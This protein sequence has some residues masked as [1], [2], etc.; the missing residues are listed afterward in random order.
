MKAQ[1]I[2]ENKVLPRLIIDN[3]YFE[4]VN[5]GYLIISI[6]FVNNSNDTLR[7][8]DTSGQ[9][10]DFFVSSD[11]LDLR[12]IKEEDSPSV[13]Q[14]ILA[15]QSSKHIN[16]KLKTLSLLKGEHEFKIAM[17]FHPLLETRNF[18]HE[19]RYQST[20]ILTDSIWVTFDRYE[21]TYLRQEEWG[22]RREL[23]LPSTI[24]SEA[25]S[26]DQHTDTL[27][28]DER[29]ITKTFVYLFI[30]NA[31][32]KIRVWSEE[33]KLKKYECFVVPVTIHNYGDKTIYYASWS[34]S[35]YF[36]YQLNNDK[37]SIS[38]NY[39]DKNLRITIEVP[40]HTTRTQAVVIVSA[41]DIL[42]YSEVTKI[43]LKVNNMIWSNEVHLKTD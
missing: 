1:G 26:L 21:G 39:C 36:D 27:T 2:K 41:D 8:W 42:K 22:E 43:G 25:N 23:T 11:S 3:C 40:P 34:C 12:L 33:P 20:K 5:H 28:V 31:K 29:E 7:Y 16:L 19:T 35:W 13:K 9:L 10:D 38:S 14:M 17:K 18:D 30:D 37:L 32:N 15:P 24:V 4:T 6:Y